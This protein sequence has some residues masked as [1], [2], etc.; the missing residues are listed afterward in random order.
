MERLEAKYAAIANANAAGRG[1]EGERGIRR[2]GN[3]ASA[4]AW[5]DDGDASLGQFAAAS[6]NREEDEEADFDADTFEGAS[7][8]RVGGGQRRGT[9]P[10]HRSAGA[11]PRGGPSDDDRHADALADILGYG[12]GGRSR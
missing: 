5:P 2:R 11:P 9:T 8:Y 6:P 10:P 1:G 3:A 4:A 7:S 12:H